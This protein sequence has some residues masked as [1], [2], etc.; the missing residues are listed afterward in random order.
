M[1]V[2]LV[3]DEPNVLKTISI[4]LESMN[5]QVDTCSSP[6]E[7]L[8]VTRR[9]DR[10]YD[11]A[12]L[13][14]QMYPI[15]GIDLMRRIQLLQ[16][17]ITTV[18]I[19]AHGTVGTAVEAI[20]KGAYDYLQKPFDLEELRQ[21]IARVEEH[22]V[23]KQ[24]REEFRSRE[25][26]E[27]EVSIITQNPKMIELIA[28][29]ERVADTPLSILIEGESGTGKELF[30]Q[31]V[32]SK[33]KRANKPFVKVNCAALPENL[34]ESEL[35][36][37]VKGAFTGAHQDRQGRFELADGGTIFLDEIGEMPVQ[38]QAKLLRV[39]QSGEFERLGESVTQQVDVRVIAATN[40]NLIDEISAGRFRE[41]LFYRLNAIRLKVPPLR[42][43]K[44]DIPLLAAFF[45]QQYAPEERTDLRLSSSALNALRGYHWKGNVRELENVI[46]RAMYLARGEEI[47]RD[48]LP[49]DFQELSGETPPQSLEEVER[50]HIQRVIAESESYEEAARKL[51]I[52]PA[53]LWRKRKK[54]DL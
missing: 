8:D 48:D 53:T 51:D 32:H 49:D 40:R 54:Y 50:D 7:A 5:F 45:I 35:F 23:Q 43:R 1:N 33:S 20:K 10:L 15:D 9:Q 38:L 3:D 4:C 41:D 17:Q 30:A 22:H 11:L 26:K 36:G 21:F 24:R 12:F 28:L 31:L 42:E 27:G 14:L 16:P 34:L 2:L 37:H 29:A 47:E 13:D 18:I 44:D 6:L 46:S 25:L 52:D 39:L 19:T